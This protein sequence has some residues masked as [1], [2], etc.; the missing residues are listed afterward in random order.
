[1]HEITLRR[2]WRIPMYA[3]LVVSGVFAT[4]DPSRLVIR[5]VSFVVAI[6]WAVAMIVSAL[7]CLFGALTDRWIGEYTGLPLL[8]SVLALYGGSAL[9]SYSAE[10]GFVILAYGAVVISFSFGLMARWVDVK[11]VKKASAG[12]YR[13][14]GD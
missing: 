12:G 4:I 1:M 14:R 11:L 9:L 7:I 2:G 3:G 5:Q 13:R 10:T 6:L 8:A